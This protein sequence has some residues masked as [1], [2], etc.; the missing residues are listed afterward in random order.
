MAKRV[1]SAKKQAS[2]AVQAPRTSRRSG[3]V[4]AV[5]NA[6]GDVYYLTRDGE[7]VKMPPA[8][9]VSTI[10]RGGSILPDPSLKTEN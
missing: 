2:R 8:A 6:H 9:R 3:Q 7:L 1:Y 10:V 5:V 4:K